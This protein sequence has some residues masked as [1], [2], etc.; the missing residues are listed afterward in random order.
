MPIYKGT[1][2]NPLQQIPVGGKECCMFKGDTLV[3]PDALIYST[4][5]TGEY[6]SHGTFF[7]APVGRICKTLREVYNPKTYE[8]GS[9]VE[10]KSYGEG[11]YYLDINTTGYYDII[12][13]A[14][15]RN[16]GGVGLYGAISLYRYGWNPTENRYTN[17]YPLGESPTF[18]VDE[19]P[20]TIELVLRRQYLNSNNALLFTSALFY[21]NYVLESNATVM[22]NKVP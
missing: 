19:T 18:F 20:L 2:S 11:L 16:T 22:I 6:T 13:R 10:L 4:T 14:T 21:Y 17:E 5:E 1:S 9:N 3:H 15:Y 8:S 7:A 12:W